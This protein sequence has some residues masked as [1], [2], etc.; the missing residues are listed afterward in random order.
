MKLLFLL[1]EKLYAVH[2]KADSSISRLFTLGIKL[3]FPILQ[4]L[5]RKHYGFQ[6]SLSFFH[7]HSSSSDAGWLNGMYVGYW[8]DREG[9]L[10]KLAF[11]FLL[12]NTRCI[13][14]SSRMVVSTMRQTEHSS[15]FWPTKFSCNL[16]CPQHNIFCSLRKSGFSQGRFS[17]S[18]CFHFP[19]PPQPQ[20]HSSNEG[21]MKQLWFTIKCH[22]SPVRI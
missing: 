22:S 11:S 13:L 8:N 3:C 7:I 1:Q 18:P 10:P 14:V 19:Y 16:F 21:K 4:A 6:H 20:L 5:F 15:S 9:I 17:F 12:T 2:E